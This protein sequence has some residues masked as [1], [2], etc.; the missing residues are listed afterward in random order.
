MLEDEFKKSEVINEMYKKQLSKD[1]KKFN[2]KEI[3]N[4]PVVEV[5]YNIWQRV[6]KDLLRVKSPKGLTTFFTENERCFCA[7]LAKSK[8]RIPDGGTGP[9]ATGAGMESQ[10]RR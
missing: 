6:L 5:K 1:I 2:P 4:T 9:S 10:S 8:P 3:K 7:K